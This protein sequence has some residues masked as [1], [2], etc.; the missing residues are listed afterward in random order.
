MT[1]RDEA[2]MMQGISEFRQENKP[3]L[4]EPRICLSQAFCQVESNLANFR[5]SHIALRNSLDALEGELEARSA[6]AMGYGVVRDMD[7]ILTAVASAWGIPGKS[8]MRHEQTLDL[9]VPRQVAM[10]LMFESGN[11]KKS[12]GRYFAMHHTTVIHSLNVIG[13]KIATNP[14]IAAKAKLA[15]YQP[16]TVN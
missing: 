13:A 16:E 1:E 10:F 12:I 2:L 3:A 9:V 11:S 6:K 15:G 4:A 8:I 14:S 5:A 7:A